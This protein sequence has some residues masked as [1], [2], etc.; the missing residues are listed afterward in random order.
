M[1]IKLSSTWGSFTVNSKTWKIQSQ[2]KVNA[3]KLESQ[4]I[5]TVEPK[6]ILVI[7][8]TKEFKNNESQLCC[9]ELF[10]RNIQNP[11]IITFDELYERAK[12]IVSNQSKPIK[13]E[14]IF[15]EDGLPF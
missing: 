8:N 14:T 5:Y 9:F 1:V 15:E 7:G 10:R 2:E 3:K 11:E 13:S 12:F 4:K 6:G